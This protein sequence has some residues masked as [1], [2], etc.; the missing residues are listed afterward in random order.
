MSNVLSEERE[1]VSFRLKKDTKQML[2]L[3]AEATGRT[4]TVLAETAIKQFC[5]LQQWQINAVE[6]GI[7]A[8]DRGALDSHEDVKSKW[9]KKRESCLV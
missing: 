2:G 3:L 5:D 7:E 9:M 6:E 4:Q 1:P 8:A